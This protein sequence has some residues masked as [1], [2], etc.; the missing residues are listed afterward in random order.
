M[1]ELHDDARPRSVIT[2]AAG[3]GSTSSPRPTRSGV[4]RDLGSQERELAA[5]E[6]DRQL[7]RMLYGAGLAGTLCARGV[8]RPWPPVEYQQV[9]NEEIAGFEYPTR[10][11]APTLCQCMARHPR[12]RQ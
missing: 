10:F 4:L 11:Q 1:S 2:R 8:R 5:V 7:Q 9:L 12:L 6:R 3:S